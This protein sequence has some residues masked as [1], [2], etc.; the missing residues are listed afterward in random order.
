MAKAKAITG[1]NA[2]APVAMNASL[3][4]QARLAELYEWEPVV[5]EPDNAR[6]LHNMRIAAKRLRYTFE[7]FEEVLPEAGKAIV[8]E[9]TQLQDELGTLHDSDVMIALL[10]LRLAADDTEPGA[11]S[12]TGAVPAQ[13]EGK[14]LVSPDMARVPA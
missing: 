11:E 12:G 8:D 6:G 5:D 7:V 10:Q 13:H 9:L 2:Q 14:P 3:I 4:A 1:L